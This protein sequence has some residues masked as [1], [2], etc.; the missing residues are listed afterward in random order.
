M[1]GV[2]GAIGAEAIRLSDGRYGN[3]PDVG[4]VVSDDPRIWQS[5]SPPLRSVSDLGIRPGHPK[6]SQTRRTP[7]KLGRSLTLSGFII[8]IDLRQS[9]PS[10]LRFPTVCPESVLSAASVA[11]TSDRTAADRSPRLVLGRLG[12]S[13]EPCLRRSGGKAPVSRV[14]RPRPIRAFA[15]WA[16]TR[17]A[18]WQITTPRR[19]LQPES[20]VAFRGIRRIFADAGDERPTRC[21][22]VT[23]AL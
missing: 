2:I 11:V 4:D 20:L 14:D 23:V 12:S 10:L 1:T 6:S 9:E 3:P 5:T 19:R 22:S 17:R 13:F 15:V 16:C 7:R 8:R 18:G 21:F